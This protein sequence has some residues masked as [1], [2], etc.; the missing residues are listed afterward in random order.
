MGEKFDEFSKHMAGQK[1]SRRGLFKLFGAGAVG[2]AAASAFAGTASAGRPKFNGTFNHTV[3]HINTT[4]PAP[5]INQL[6][7]VFNQLLPAIEVA[8]KKT[9]IDF[10]FLKKLFGFN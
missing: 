9:G 3:P 8:E 4:L 10:S 1:H 2:A 5:V 6:A 7:P